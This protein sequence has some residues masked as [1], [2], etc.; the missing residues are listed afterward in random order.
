MN[1]FLISCRSILISAIRRHEES[2]WCVGA[3]ARACVRARERVYSLLVFLNRL[4][5]FCVHNGLLFFVCD[6]FLVRGLENTTEPESTS[7]SSMFKVLFVCID[8]RD[9]TTNQYNGGRAQYVLDSKNQWKPFWL[10]TQLYPENDW[11]GWQNGVN[12]DECAQAPFNV[13]LNA[14]F[15]YVESLSRR[16]AISCRN[17]LDVYEEWRLSF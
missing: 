1:H 16:R 9:C 3:C 13:C 15:Q 10:A 5:I 14:F 6:S 4:A 17:A 7:S 8:R 11:T 12:D 2:E